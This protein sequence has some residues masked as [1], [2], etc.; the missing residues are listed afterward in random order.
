MK[1]YKAVVMGATGGV[2]A[3]LVEKLM[4]SSHC[5]KI[6]VISRKRIPKNPKL[7]NIIWDDFSKYLLETKNENIEVFK[8]ND[9]LFCCLGAPEKALL[10]L[11]YNKKKYAPMFQKVDYDYVVAAARL[12]KQ[13][14]IT[15]FSVIS[16]P[17]AD[18]KAKF[19]YSR[20]KGEMEQSIKTI[21]FKKVSFFR[22]YHL[23]KPANNRM[24]FFKR[25]FKN[26]VAFI[27]RMMPAAQRAIKVEDVA[28]AM[29]LEL[30]SRPQKEEKFSNYSSDDMR[31][32]I[33][34][35]K[36]K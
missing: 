1:K 23:M 9:V 15:H 4:S 11:F 27:A 3:Y 22:P 14:D 31:E 6:T 26:F 28:T 12:A 2:G 13:A 20:I 10:G 24:T 29:M 32:I 36:S 19:L 16:S 8:N 30:E 17:T 21:G 25:I 7:N 34:L 35:Y 33:K 18:P 5:S